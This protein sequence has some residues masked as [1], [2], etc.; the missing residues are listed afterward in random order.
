[1]Y[2][3]VIINSHWVF[4]SLWQM[5]KT[6]LDDFVLQKIQL[7][8][9]EQQSTETILKYA[10]PEQIEVKYGGSKPNIEAPF[11]PPRL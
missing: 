7:T 5:V 3:N 10:A 8:K 9:N 6:W 4:K 1:M 2:R 11:F